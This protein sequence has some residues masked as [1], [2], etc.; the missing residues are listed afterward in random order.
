[1]FRFVSKSILSIIIA[2]L[3]AVI[4]SAV[5]LYFKGILKIELPGKWSKGYERARAAVAE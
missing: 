1:M 4:I 3:A 5:V 2:T